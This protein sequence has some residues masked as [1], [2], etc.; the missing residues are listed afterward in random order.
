MFTVK[1]IA[2]LVFCFILWYS[3]G[4]ILSDLKL[5]IDLEDDEERERKEKEKLHNTKTYCQKWH[6]SSKRHAVK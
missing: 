2:F 6:P 5:Q 1:T 4:P 3:A